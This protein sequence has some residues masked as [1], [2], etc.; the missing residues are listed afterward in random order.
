MSDSCSA[1]TGFL[2]LSPSQICDEFYRQGDY[3]RQLNLPVTPLCD[4][5]RMSV[6]KIQTGSYNVLFV[7]CK[8]MVS[9]IGHVRLSLLLSSLL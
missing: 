1:V 6:E 5:S 3:E 4:S 9:V 2:R 8:L 7:L